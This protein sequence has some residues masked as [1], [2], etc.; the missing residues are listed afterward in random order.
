MSTLVNSQLSRL[1]AFKHGLLGWRTSDLT[2]ELWVWLVKKSDATNLN[3]S[4]G[5]FNSFE[6]S[7]YFFISFDPKCNI[8]INFHFG[9]EILANL[10]WKSEIC[11]I[12]T[13][14]EKFSLSWDNFQNSTLTSIKELLRNEEFT[15]VTLVC[16]DEKQLKTHKVILSAS[17]PFFR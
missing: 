6:N 7:K 16:D 1:S 12:L 5:L 10:V 15:D 9:N 13:M 11:I 2:T 8:K 14:L 4:R 17:S 3:L